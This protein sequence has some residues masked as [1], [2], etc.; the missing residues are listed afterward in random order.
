MGDKHNMCLAFFKYCDVQ[1]LF[2]EEYEVEE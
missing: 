1:P 2:I